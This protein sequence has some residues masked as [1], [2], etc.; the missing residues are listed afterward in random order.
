MSDFLVYYLELLHCL[1]IWNL[2]ENNILGEQGISV[3]NVNVGHLSCH[4]RNFL[5]NNDCLIL[6]YEEHVLAFKC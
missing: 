1:V 2:F 5:H 4:A 6:S 3:L